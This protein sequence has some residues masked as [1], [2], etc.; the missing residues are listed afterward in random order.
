MFRTTTPLQRE[1]WMRHG[2]EIFE[3]EVRSKLEGQNPDDYLLI[4]VDSGDFEVDAD[5]LAASERLRAR[6]PQAV[7]YFRRVGSRVSRRFGYRREKR[8][9]D[10]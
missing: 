8:L 2:E 6:R 1:Q 9:N 10:D 5:E 4:D 3:R 7:I